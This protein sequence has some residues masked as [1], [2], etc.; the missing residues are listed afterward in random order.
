M[1]IF[2]FALCFVTLA[3]AARPAPFTADSLQIS[4]GRFTSPSA[5]WH[6]G[7]PKHPQVYVWFHGGMQSS[8]CAK[9]YEAGGMFVPILEKSSKE[10]IV[11]SVSACKEN[12]W[13]TQS[14]LKAVD[15]MLDSVAARFQIPVDTVSLVGISDGGLGVAGYTLYGKRTVKARLLVSTN[16]SAVSDADNLSKTMKVRQ[17]AWTFL[18]GGSDRLYPSNRTLPWMERFCAALGSKQCKIR[19][20]ERGE[21]DWSWWIS[22]RESWIRDFVP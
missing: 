19:Y 17:G 22:N 5:V 4:V 8:K 15:V 6:R 10:N 20:D 1:K 11:V 9:G 13:L 3:F 2:A 14:T 12:H 21:H 7:V 18:Q 16:L